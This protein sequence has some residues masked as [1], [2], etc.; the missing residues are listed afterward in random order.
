[1]MSTWL[2]RPPEITSHELDHPL[3]NLRPLLNEEERRKQA[4]RNE[5]LSKVLGEETL[6]LLSLTCEDESGEP[7]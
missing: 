5:R 1:M 6:F 3:A 2:P 4:E 7:E